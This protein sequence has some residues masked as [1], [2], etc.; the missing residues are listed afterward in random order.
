MR[1]DLLVLMAMVSLVNLGNTTNASLRKTGTAESIRMGKDCGGALSGLRDGE[2]ASSGKG[3]YLRGQGE[4]K[5]GQTAFFLDSDG[6]YRKV[7]ITEVRPHSV[8]YRDPQT[9]RTGN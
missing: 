9:G 7:E 2:E 3:V 8:F 1:K 5:A 4:P 6:K